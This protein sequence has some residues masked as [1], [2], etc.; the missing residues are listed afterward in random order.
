MSKPSRRAFLKTSAALA[1]GTAVLRNA[2]AFAAPTAAT[3]TATPLTQFDYHEIQLLDG[4]ML[5]QFQQNHALFLNLNEDSILKPF[6]QLT[7]MPAPGEDL[8]GWYS[9]SSLFDPPKNMTGYVPGHTFGQWLS[10]LSRAYAITGDKPTQAKVQRLVAGFAP[11]VSQKFYVDYCIPAY[12]F[13]KTNCGLI[14][15]HQFAGNPQALAVLNRATDAVLPFLPAKALDREEMAARPHKNISFTWDE[16]Y[17]LPENFYLAYQRGAGARYRQLAQRFLED[18][19]Y[20]GPLSENINMLPGQHAYSHVNGLCSAM[21]CYLTDGSKKHL[22]AAHN[23]FAFVQQQSYATGGWGP[24][25]TFQKPGTDG[26]ADS[27]THT[28][29]SFETPCGAYGHFKI[30]RYLMRV[31]GDSRYGDSMETVLYNT[32]LGAR[33]IKSDGIS[34]YYADYNHNASKFDYEQK[35][36]CCSGTFPQL[37][38]DYGISTYLRSTKGINVNLYVPSRITWQQGGTRVSLT[39]QTQYPAVGD[40]AM[41]LT[42]SKPE[43]FT[44]ALRIP[45]WAGS[46]TKVTVNGNAVDATITPGTWA[47]LDRTWKDGDR[48]E[49]SLDMPLRLAPL[50]DRH[51]QLVALLHGPVA[52]FAIEPVPQTITQKQLLAAQRIGNSSAWEVATSSGKIRMLPY[53]AITNESYRLY[54][55]T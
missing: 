11:T 40:T 14:D 13:D 50:D 44:I 52:L 22:A 32:V 41:H 1:A 5:V 8:G 34:F 43:R 39:Q 42:L 17:T 25:E 3:I 35:W 55:Q 6:R 26:L 36:P 33:P 37:A 49:L 9:P 38:A 53:P 12:T 19:T 31:T 51:P 45:A 24:D 27:L 29:S 46:K 48:V 30:T 21:Q 15:A 16:T 7:G 54:Q 4:P 18:D 20:F 10:G 28:H 47:N 2:P 23:G